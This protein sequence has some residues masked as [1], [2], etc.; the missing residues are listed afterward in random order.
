MT[1]QFTNSFLLII[2]HLKLLRLL[3]IIASQVYVIGED[4][5]LKELELAGFQHLGGPVYLSFL[6][7]VNLRT[8]DNML[9]SL[10]SVKV[11]VIPSNICESNMLCFGKSNDRMSY[12]LS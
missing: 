4:G 2:N 3:K 11:H 9:N 12:L 1:L 10:C 8:L 6:Y 5:I 7:S